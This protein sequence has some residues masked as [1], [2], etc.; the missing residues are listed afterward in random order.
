MGLLLAARSTPLPVIEVLYCSD[1]T[2]CALGWHCFAHIEPLCLTFGAGRPSCHARHVSASEIG[3]PP[4]RSSQSTFYRNNLLSSSGTSVYP[5]RGCLRSGAW[6]RKERHRPT[7]S[8][9][10]RAQSTQ[11]KIIRCIAYLTKKKQGKRADTVQMNTG[12][13]WE[14]HSSTGVNKLWHGRRSI[15]TVSCLGMV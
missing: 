12:L 2:C 7:T 11:W 4:F 15:L 8:P 1:V 10:A 13:G 5:S 6:G 3:R 14:I 9:G